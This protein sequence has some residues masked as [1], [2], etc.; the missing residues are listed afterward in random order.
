MA[1]LAGS[2]EE[3]NLYLCLYLETSMLSPI[4]ATPEFLEPGPGLRC[5]SPWAPGPASW[6]SWGLMVT[7]KATWMV[8][9]LRKRPGLGAVGSVMLSCLLPSALQSVQVSETESPL[10]D[11]ETISVS[12]ITFPYVIMLRLSFPFLSGHKMKL[13]YTLNIIC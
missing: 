8:L 4:Q 3:R 9:L 2:T 6:G 11:T 5:Q 10:W 7:P 1:G 13:K 12:R